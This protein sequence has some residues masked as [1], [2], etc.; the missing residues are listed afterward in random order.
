ME[1]RLNGKTMRRGIAKPHPAATN[2]QRILTALSSVFQTPQARGTPTKAQNIAALA[3]SP[4]NPMPYEHDEPALPA[5]AVAACSLAT[6]AS[7]MCHFASTGL[8]R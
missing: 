8:I 6:S 2:G 3:S 1:K 7:L 5:L 4:P